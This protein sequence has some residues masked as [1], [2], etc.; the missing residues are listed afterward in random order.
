MPD[1]EPQLVTSE[2]E[3][4][5]VLANGAKLVGESVLP[6]ASLY[7]DGE[8]APGLVHTAAG[9]GARAW[10]GAFGPIG[11]VLV[12]ANSYSKSVTDRHL[13]EHL[14]AQAPQ[15]VRIEQD[16]SRHQ[17]QAEQRRSHKRVNV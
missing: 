8:L 13:H 3:P 7:L 11:W 17:L 9:L 15:G 6:G 4:A 16:K 12:A 5:A 1:P 10:L 14:L 2:T